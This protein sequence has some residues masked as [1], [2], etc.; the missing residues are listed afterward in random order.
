[1]NEVFKIGEDDVIYLSRSGQESAVYGKNLVRG[2]FDRELI[3]IG[4]VPVQ[5]AQARWQAILR[6][7]SKP[8]AFTLSSE[9][10]FDTLPRIIIVS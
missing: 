1:M 7:T 9:V 10:L 2:A 3:T 5:H 6:L 8:L 4:G